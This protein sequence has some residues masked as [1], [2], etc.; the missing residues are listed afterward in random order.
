MWNSHC[1]AT[2]S[3]TGNKYNQVFQDQEIGQI[4]WTK[5]G[6]R[7]GITGGN[8]DISAV[9]IGGIPQTITSTVSSL[10]MNMYNELIDYLG[11]N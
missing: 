4:A 9:G 10:K 5:Y 8:Y 7:T 2:F 6:F 1:I 11:Q 3:E